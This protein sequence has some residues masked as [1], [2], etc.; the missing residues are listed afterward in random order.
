MKIIQN[1]IV[2]SKLSKEIEHLKCYIVIR[3]DRNSKFKAY[4]V[5]IFTCKNGKVLAKPFY[6]KEDYSDIIYFDDEENTSNHKLVVCDNLSEAE[7]LAMMFNRYGYVSNKFDL[8]KLTRDKDN[9]E[10]LFQKFCG[11]IYGFE[12]PKFSKKVA[13]NELMTFEE[14][15][16]NKLI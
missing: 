9:I 15:M 16:N 12:K 5:E 4:P 8:E 7:Y 1:L 11:L 10:E 13:C 14:Q 2:G 6:N 3:L